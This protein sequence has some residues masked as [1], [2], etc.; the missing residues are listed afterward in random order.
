MDKLEN[1]HEYFVEWQ[2]LLQSKCRDAAINDIERAFVQLTCV[3]TQ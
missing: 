3:N 2:E 1:S